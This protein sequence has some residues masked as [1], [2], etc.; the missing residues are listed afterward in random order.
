MAYESWK[1][2]SAYET[3]GESEMKEVSEAIKATF[4]KREGPVALACGDDRGPT[5]ESLKALAEQ[6]VPIESAYMRCFGGVYGATR[7]LLV[8]GVAQHGPDVIEQIGDNFLEAAQNTARRASEHGVVMISHSSEG[9][10]DNPARLN[11]GA[12]SDIACAYAA[13]VGKVGNLTAFDQL[14]IRSAEYEASTV[15]GYP[16][17][18]NMQRVVSANRLLVD[19]VFGRKEP[20]SITKQDLIQY[21]IRAMILSGD[22]APSKQARRVL[23]FTE[24]L[25]ADPREANARGLH[26]YGTDVTQLVEILIKAWPEFDLDAEL[27]VN[28]IIL[29]EVG[30][31]AALAAIDGAADPQRIESQRLGDPHA[32]LAHLSA[33]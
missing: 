12:G 2:P 3:V 25:I 28:A 15:F 21:K 11:L 8:A 20:L 30:T 4:I 14:V 1:R 7:V 27:L 10:E 19:N 31:T 33:L 32:A 6:G 23:N 5:D 16:Q 22:H 13:G 29:D 26:F 24:N 9:A 18:N 17:E